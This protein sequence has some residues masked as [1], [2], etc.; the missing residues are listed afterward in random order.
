MYVAVV[1]WAV[2]GR[3]EKYQDFGTEAD[4][5]SHAV[6]FGGFVAPDPG[7]NFD[8]WKVVGETLEIDPLPPVYP[9]V[10]DWEAFQGRFTALEFDD[11]TDYVYASNTTTGKPV[12]GKLIQ[13]LSRVMAKDKVDLE[14]AKTDAFLDILVSAG[15]VSAERKAEILTP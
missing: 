4:A 1:K 13:A 8:D 14:D 2:D 3:V 12:R 11:A 9:T 5:N 15:I 10:I 6:E 7:G